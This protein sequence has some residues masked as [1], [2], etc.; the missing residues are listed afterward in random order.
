MA[1]DDFADKIL[2]DEE[3]DSVTGGTYDEYKEIETMFINEPVDFQI[4]PEQV[5]KWL[6]ENLNIDATFYNDKNTPNVYTRDGKTLKQSEVIF[7]GLEKLLNTRPII[8][9]D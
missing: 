3:L 5:Q 7:N 8:S 1:N 4:T 6:K 9:T 2:S